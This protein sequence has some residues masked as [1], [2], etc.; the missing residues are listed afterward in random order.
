M[1]GRPKKE[2]HQYLT[3]NRASNISHEEYML[4]PAVAFLRYCISAKSAIDLCIRHLPK[5][6]N[7]DYTKD[8]IDSLQHLVIASLPTIMGHFETYQRSLFAGMFDITVYL[9]KFDIEKFF[10][11]LSKE[12]SVSIDLVRLAAYRGIGSKS[13]GTLL[14]DSLK[15]WH[16]PKTVNRYFS[17]FGLNFTAFGNDE[18][19]KLR[20]LWQLRH[21][22]VHTGCTLTLSDAQK[23]TNLSQHAGKQIVFENNFIFEVARKLHPIVKQTTTGLGNAFKQ[24]LLQNINKTNSDNIDKFFEVKSSVPSWLRTA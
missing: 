4:S 16:E 6:Q 9:Q 22:I 11:D 12:T 5:N 13:I 21:S 18:S 14:A 3:N 10:K 24:R 17:A 7:N 20:V 19:E 15:G 23:V 2:F 1:P 8:S